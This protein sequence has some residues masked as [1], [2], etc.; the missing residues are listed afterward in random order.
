[1]TTTTSPTLAQYAHDRIVERLE[2]GI[3]YRPERPAHPYQVR[4]YPAPA[5]HLDDPLAA[6]AKRDELIDKRKRGEQI[7]RPRRKNDPILAEVCGSFLDEQNA[8]H[9]RGEARASTPRYYR[10][11]T[12]VWRTRDADEDGEPRYAYDPDDPLR[13]PFADLRLS[14]L[15]ALAIGRWL[16]RVRSVATG[17]QA[18]LERQALLKVLQ[19]AELDGARVDPALRLIPPP[20]RAR[21]DDRRRRTILRL[22]ELELL[23]ESTPAY[24]REIVDV[25]GR[26]GARL[27]EWTTLTDDRVDLDAGTIFIPAELTKEGRDKLIP[28][29]PAEVRAMRR[30]LLARAPGTRLVAPKARGAEFTK[31]SHFY[32]LVW[33][34]ALR[35][36]AKAWRQE[37]GYGDDVPTPFDGYQFKWLRR[38]AVALM[39]QAGLEPELIAKRLGHADTGE[40]VLTVYREVD[41]EI[42][43]FDALAELGDSLGDAIEARRA[44]RTAANE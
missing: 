16:R 2:R 7:R 27:R 3:R 18:R 12:R 29:L 39:R 34:P 23:V 33:E 26:C 43:L 6:I 8:R 4:I 32:R 36:A 35:R 20:P 30:Q 15:D 41:E 31:R 25:A 40:L 28:L 19:L 13:E 11:T 14:E 5:E 10:E 9:E 42:E 38:T 17:P 44:A 22:D 21:R 24:W 37:R 1:M